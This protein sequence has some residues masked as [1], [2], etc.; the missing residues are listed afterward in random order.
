MC[1]IVSSCWI[2]K[3]EY[4]ILHSFFYWLDPE[5]NLMNKLFCPLKDFLLKLRLHI[6]KNIG[7]TFLV[8]PSHTWHIIIYITYFTSPTQLF[9][10][11]LYPLLFKAVHST[12]RTESP[13]LSD[14]LNSGTQI[15]LPT[16]PQSSDIM[17]KY[18]KGH[19]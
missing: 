10:K 18:L 8:S 2:L 6:Q 15:Q 19:F 9:V 3:C 4:K 13:N 5:C 1:R 17:C 11:N 12:E 7:F 16:D 14:L